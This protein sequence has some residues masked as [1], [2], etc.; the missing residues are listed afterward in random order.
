MRQRYI[1]L[2]IILAFIAGGL[3]AGFAIGDWDGDTAI[4]GNLP[5]SLMLLLGAVSAFGCL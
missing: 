4:R 5:I 1:T 3:G 2:L